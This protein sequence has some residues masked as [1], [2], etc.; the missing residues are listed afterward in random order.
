MPCAMSLW[1]GQPS[2]IE[3]AARYYRLVAPGLIKYPKTN[4][5]IKAATK[6]YAHRGGEDGS[7]GSS[8][9]DTAISLPVASV[10]YSYDG[11]A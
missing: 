11:R 9:D 2:P 4:K 5:A 8:S 6:T 1:S 3:S 10:A 7:L